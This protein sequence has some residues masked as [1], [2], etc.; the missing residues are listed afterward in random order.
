MVSG[1]IGFISIYVIFGILFLM[2]KGSGKLLNRIS[3]VMAK[4]K[5]TLCAV[6]FTLLSFMFTLFYIMASIV[7]GNSFFNALICAICLVFSWFMTEGFYRLVADEKGNTD[8]KLKVLSK[9][10][11]NVCNLWA[12]IGVA[13]SSGMLCYKEKNLEYASLVSVAISLWMGTYI[14]ISEIYKGTS[15]KKL[16]SAIVREFRSEKKSVWISSVLCSVIVTI[17]VLKNE[18]AIKINSII[19]EFGVGAAIG[20][21]VLILIMTIAVVY[22]NRRK[23]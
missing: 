4:G 21:W 17:L 7:T 23:K 15:I 9:E 3:A 2:M 8:E 20:T 5:T 19:Q 14:S 16:I 10:D 12:L 18:I 22:R 11:K 13:I 6:L 1:V